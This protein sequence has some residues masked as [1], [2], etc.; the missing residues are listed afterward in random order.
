VS[1]VLSTRQPICFRDSDRGRQLEHFVY[2]V[3]DESGEV[4]RVAILGIDISDR[5]RM[6]KELAL[7]IRLASV[8]VLAASFAHRIRNPLA[9]VSAAAQMLQEQPDD[10][11]LCSELTGTILAAIQRASLITE[12][13]DRCSMPGS[14]RL[15]QTKVD[16]VLERVLE[17]QAPYLSAHGVKLQQRIRSGLPSVWGNDLLLQEL[18]HNLVVNACGAMPL[19][20]VLEVRAEGDR[21]TGLEIKFRDTGPGMTAADLSEVFDPFR[22]T[23]QKDGDFG[24]ELFMARHI[25]AQHHGTITVASAPGEGTTFSI[26]LPCGPPNERIV[27]AW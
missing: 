26:R 7:A 10:A 15:L 2:P 20:G 4:Q 6:H 12:D 22:S 19:G 14:L 8:G 13:L 5:V 16:A 9:V 25:V 18:F 3:T 11:E 1:R 21:E 24:L 27:N 23:E 17:L